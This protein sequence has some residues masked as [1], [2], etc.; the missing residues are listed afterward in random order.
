MV[1]AALGNSTVFT[2]AVITAGDAL[3]VL[4]ALGA[5]ALPVLERLVAAA[6]H[7]HAVSRAM[8]TG[9]LAAAAQIALGMIGCAPG[10][11]RMLPSMERD[12]ASG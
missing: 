1:V 7:R 3:K 5:M 12:E 11:T 10:L 9:A 6:A 2:P 4:A 8:A